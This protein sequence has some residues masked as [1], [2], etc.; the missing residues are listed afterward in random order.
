MSSAKNDSRV[1]LYFFYLA[2]GETTGIAEEM[3]ALDAL[4]RI[5]NITDSSKPLPFGKYVHDEIP[6]LVEEKINVKK[7]SQ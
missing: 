2:P 5:F 1:T 4:R 7:L 6:K 3:A